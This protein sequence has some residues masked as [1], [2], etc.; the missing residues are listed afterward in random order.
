MNAWH[1]GQDLRFGLRMLRSNPGFTTV[2]VLMLALGIGANTAIFTLIHALLLKSLPSV[3][4]SSINSLHGGEQGWGPTKVAAAGLGPSAEDGLDVRG[5]AVG[6]G[7]FETM[8][9]P[10]L[11]GR[12]F[13]P[14]DEF[15][16]GDTQTN[17]APRPVILDQTSARR[18]FGD[19]NP[20]GRLLQASGRGM[21]WPPLEVVGVV[22]DVIHKKL[23]SGP[24]ISIYGLETHRSWALKFF[25]VRTVGSPR[26]VASGIRQIVR[27]LDPKVE[28]S[29]LR[30]MDELINA[31][32]L[33]ERTLS[34]LASFFSMAALALASLGLYGIL[35][36][37]VVRRRR[38][39]GL[40]MAL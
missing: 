30:S 13:G 34:E 23:R 36:Y 19:E 31:Q 28:V 40:R 20:V 15:S 1:L 17:Q 27:E 14:Q 16:A 35:S 38:E 32:L 18:L 3:S 10:L 26:A 6:P 37:G 21:S 39:I 7:N 24:R 33:Q 5:T 4:V 9:I 22:K 11:M 2:A 25:H 8:G 12:A 29:N